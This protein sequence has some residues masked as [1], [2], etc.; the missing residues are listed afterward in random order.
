M[1]NP[2]R[3]FPLAT[4]ITFGTTVLALLVV[5]QTSGVLTGSAAKWV[6]AAAGVL[7]V[8]LTAYARQHTTPVAAPRDAYGRRLVPAQGQPLIP[9]Q[10]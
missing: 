6:D 1:I 7:Q 3:K 2:F 9:P 8:V 5:L 10:Q 4:L